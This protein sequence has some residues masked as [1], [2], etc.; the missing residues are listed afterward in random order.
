M[1]SSAV[2]GSLTP[3]ESALEAISDKSKKPKRGSCLKLRVFSI[4]KYEAIV[5]KVSESTSPLSLASERSG[6][7]KLP[8]RT[9]REIDTSRSSQ[10]F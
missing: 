1:I 8:G 2:P 4:T 10:I 7:V 9:S 3:V 6:Y 5:F